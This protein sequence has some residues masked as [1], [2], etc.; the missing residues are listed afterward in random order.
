MHY[1]IVWFSALGGP[2]FTKILTKLFFLA[3][4][5]F[6]GLKMDNTDLKLAL[7]LIMIFFLI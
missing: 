5:R 2:Y 1:T 7:N 3:F 6:K 4:S